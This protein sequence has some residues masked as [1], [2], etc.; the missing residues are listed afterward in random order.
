MRRP[1]LFRTLAPLV[2]LLVLAQV[3]A[4]AQT[5][6]TAPDN[7]YSP[8]DDVK[9]GREAAQKVEQQM[10]LL[11]ER[12]EVTDYVQQIGA[13][14][15]ESIP[16]EF[17]HPE[18][19]YQFRVVNASDLNAFALP[20]GFMYVNRGMIQAADNE[21]EIAGV[22]AHELAHVALRHGTAQVSKQSSLKSQLPAIGGVILGTI[23]GGGLGQVIAQGSVFG[24]NAYFLKYSRDYER[25][26]DVLGAQ[27]MARAG[28]D[29][30]ELA[31][32]FQTIQRES[33]SGGPEWLSDHPNPENRYERINDEA[34]A[35]GYPPNTGR[36]SSTEFRRVQEI[37]SGMAPAPTT[38]E[39]SKNGQGSSR[40]FPDGSRIERNVPYPASSYRTYTGGSVFQVRVP[41]NWR[42]FE[43][44]NSV[45]FAPEGAYGYVGD[46]G[47]FTHGA[48]IG[49][50][51]AGSRDLREATER[52][53]SS[54]LQ[55]NSYLRQQ[56]GLSADRVD[57]RD[58]YYVL[59]GGR[60]NATGRDER[61]GVT[62]TMLSSGQLLY[63]ITVVPES[64]YR[65]Y[66]R[67][68]R[69]VI[70][71]LRLNG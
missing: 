46:E 30:H 34:R 3:A 67:T 39:I 11:P 21:G 44:Q 6:I 68:F 2:C 38:S 56:T 8:S 71:S 5:R 63:I 20:G 32:V 12:G 48:M 47:V 61:V 36:G 1:S 70:E 25:Q 26:A 52:F 53:V 15:V 51:D 64:Q 43:D 23:I 57:G 69:D 19:R 13:R 7:K 55:S 9:L 28:Y 45:T 10:P 59:L 17:Q 65:A 22:M 40:R 33:G 54:L 31:D 49:V 60:S 35:L 58:A 27:M 14:L 62:T 50:A 42:E 16:P 37:L 66:D 18:F 4:S 29:P 24:V 41:T